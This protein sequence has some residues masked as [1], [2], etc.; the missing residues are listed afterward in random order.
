MSTKATFTRD[1]VCSDP[2]GT[3]S[4]LVT[5]H[6]VYTRPVPN[7]K[8][9]APRRII[10]ISGLIWYQIADPIGTGS[11]KSRVNTRL[12]RTNFVPVPNGFGP[13]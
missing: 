6:T 5:I 9:T 2:F 12:I 1:R 3:G 11:T 10:F 8:G 4:T 7:W 13:V